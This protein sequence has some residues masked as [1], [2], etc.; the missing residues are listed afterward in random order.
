MEIFRRL[1]ASGKLRAYGPP[2]T[3]MAT[4]FTTRLADAASFATCKLLSDAG[5]AA[6]AFAVWNAYRPK[7]AVA[8]AAA[9]WVANFASRMGCE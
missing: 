3:A 2:L 7:A 1:V 4:D 6:T 9:G 5:S 8:T